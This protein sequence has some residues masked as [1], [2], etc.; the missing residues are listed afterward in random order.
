MRDVDNDPIGVAFA[1]FRL[2]QAPMIRS[3]GMAAVRTTVR[4]RRRIRVIAAAVLTAIAI[5]GPAIGYVSV[6][7]WHHE[8]APVGVPPNPTVS[9]GAQTTA[10]SPSAAPEPSTPSSSSP[11][12]HPSTTTP[13]VAAC[14]AAQLTG[15]VTDGGSVASQPFVI[16]ALT[17]T[18][19]SP[20]QLTGYPQI[21][22]TGHAQSTPTVM[23]TLPI[24]VSDGS[25][26]E[27]TDP[28]PGRIELTPRGSA[29]FA[30]GTGTAYDGGAHIYE[31]TR[32]QVVV[33]EGQTAVPVTIS[34]AASAPAGQPIPI[35]VTAFVAGSA[36][37]PQ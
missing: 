21:S 12:S 23:G 2:Q 27:R 33:P 20:C 14:R 3:A 19:G 6:S 7:G 31:I 9:P 36:G 35:T 13:Q 11:S 5:A 24:R 37:P 10:G 16:I 18:S 32:L 26:Y 15:T 30:L 28:G 25:I 34:I 1:D 22:A 29:S 4:R 8:P 17:N